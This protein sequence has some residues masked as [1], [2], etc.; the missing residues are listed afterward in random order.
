VFFTKSILF[1][2]SN[3]S[4]CLSLFFLLLCSLVAT[5]N[6]STQERQ[7]LNRICQQQSTGTQSFAKGL[8]PSYRE[9]YFNR[10]TI[11][12]DDNS[13]FTAIILYT[14]QQAKEEM[15]GASKALVTSLVTNALPVFNQFQNRKGVPVYSF[16]MT[17]PKKYFP[18]TRWLSFFKSN[19][20]PDDLDCSA[21]VLQAIE[22]PKPV[23]IEMHRY[24]QA[25]QNS[26]AKRVLS[27]FKPYREL[28]AYSTWLGHKVPIDFDVCALANVLLMVNQYGLPYTKADSASLRLIEETIR[29]KQYTSCPE[30]IA[31]YYNRAPVILY[32]FSRLMAAAK[33]PALERYRQQLIE[34]AWMQYQKAN[35]FLDR[36]ILST[37]LM[38]LGAVPPAM[39]EES[40]QQYCQS[41]NNNFV[42]F[43][44]NMASMLPNPLM[45]FMLRSN[46]GRFDYYCPA[47]N[48][49]L[50]LEYLL[51]RKRMKP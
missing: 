11:R 37:A 49:A 31:P 36:I 26:R 9:Y 7:L 50:V 15:D 39:E 4:Y 48:D 20:L 42:F 25:F 47:Y 21:M 10:G 8:F 23:V 30:I 33:P 28:P 5:A 3:Y 17:K 1:L 38:R 13:F 44:A 18:N 2:K 51:L 41:P 43:V 27:T 19:A 12:D 16:W 6:D 45:R 14:L 35:N 24:I 22:A 29:S 40:I 46:I 34:E 32:H